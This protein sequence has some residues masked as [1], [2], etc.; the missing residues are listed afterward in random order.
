MSDAILLIDSLYWCQKY[1]KNAKNHV[2]WGELNSS[3]Y[4]FG[5]EGSG[6]RSR[7]GQGLGGAS[8]GIEK[9]WGRY[10]NQKGEK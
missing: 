10:G 1:Y 3:F 8:C 9:G 7:E 6:W 4:F 5:E 2:Q